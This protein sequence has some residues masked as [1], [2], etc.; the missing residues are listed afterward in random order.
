MESGPRAGLHHFLNLTLVFIP[1][2]T[3]IDFKTLKPTEPIF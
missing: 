1:A 3:Q 2:S